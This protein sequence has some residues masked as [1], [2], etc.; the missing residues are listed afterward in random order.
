MNLRLHDTHF[1]LDLF[2]DAK[3][4]VQRI[5]KAGIYTV[6]V[7][8]V[9]AV[10]HHTREMSANTKFVRAAIGFHPELVSQY[11]Q[12][13][14]QF[15]ELVGTTRYVGEV[16]LDNFNKTASDYQDQKRIFEQVL[17]ACNGLR[18]KILTVHSR[19]AERDVVSMI[20]PSFSGKVILHWYSGDLKELERALSF[21]FY[22]SVNRAMTVSDNGKRI[23]ARLPKDR[24]LLETDGPFVKIGD[25]QSTPLDVK[26][27]LFDILRLKGLED[28]P[29]D[30]VFDNFKS[31]IG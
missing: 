18:N 30:F 3:M 10:F 14:P 15:L 27:T 11:K 4:L 28:S 6:A 19:R 9:P 24:I 5:E 8:N 21:G 2:R 22:F 25:R 13:L 1:H 17:D 20:G 31:L 12:Q 23:I 7:T 26:E 16:G 29:T